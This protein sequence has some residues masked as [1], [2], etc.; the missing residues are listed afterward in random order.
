MRTSRGVLH[1]ALSS[2]FGAGADDLDARVSAAQRR[3]GAGPDDDPEWVADDLGFR[4]LPVSN[5]RDL[6]PGV[7]AEVRGDLIVYR[8]NHRDRRENLWIGIGLAIDR[9]RPGLR[10]CRPG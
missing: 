8:W 5:E 6:P 3:A 4:M 2:P 10:I 1:A 9:V 7:R